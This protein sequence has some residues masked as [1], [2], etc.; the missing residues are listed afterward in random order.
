GGATARQLRTFLERNE[1]D[2]AE[3]INN[4]VTTGDI[5]VKRIPGIRQLLIL[6]PYVVAGGYTVVSNSANAD[7]L[8]D[9]HFGLVLT[10]DPHVCAEGYGSP[11]RAPQDRTDL[12]MDEA[13]R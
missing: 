11:I 9:A 10:I 2:L 5:V 13:A 8:Y 12:P 6:Y 4:L 7:G 1:V 3:L